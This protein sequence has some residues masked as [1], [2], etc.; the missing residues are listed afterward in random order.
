MPARDMPNHLKMKYRT[1]EQLV[2]PKPE[3]LVKEEPTKTKIYDDKDLSSDDS[4]SSE[5]SD[6]DDDE[7][8]ARELEKIKRE[9]EEERRNRDAQAAADDQAARD[10][11]ARTSNPLL[12]GAVKRKW[13]D[14]VVFKHQARGVQEPKKRFI[15]DTIRNDFHKRFLQKYIH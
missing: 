4:E 14:D 12:S 9:R 11:A 3:L 6:D 1:G 2:G 7:A 5:S 10:F 13:N 8:V 15:N